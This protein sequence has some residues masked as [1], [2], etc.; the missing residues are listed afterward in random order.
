VEN[1]GSPSPL[2]TKGQDTF[3]GAGRGASNQKLATMPKVREGHAD[4]TD[5]VP[6]RV[7]RGR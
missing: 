5:G 3:L 4:Q 7:R 2:P 1:F 6:A